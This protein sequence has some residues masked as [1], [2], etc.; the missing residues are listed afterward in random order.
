MEEVELNLM[1]LL[2][3][4][5]EYIVSDGIS[6]VSDSGVPTSEET[7]LVLST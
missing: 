4:V 5:N 1:V 6:S 7:T 2:E 3:I